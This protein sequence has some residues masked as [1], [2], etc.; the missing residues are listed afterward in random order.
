MMSSSL[1]MRKYRD[2]GSLSLDATDCLPS[3]LPNCPEKCK[4][5][6]RGVCV[7][8]GEISNLLLQYRIGQRGEAPSFVCMVNT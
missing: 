6:D 5:K 3:T 8:G 7:C 2:F 1:L 4:Y